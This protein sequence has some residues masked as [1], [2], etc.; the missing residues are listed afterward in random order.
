VETFR[1]RTVAVF[2]TIQNMPEIWDRLR[3]AMRRRA[4]PCI[5]AG[6]A[7]MEHLLQC[8][9]ALKTRKLCISGPMLM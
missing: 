5:Q 2:Q 4:E 7:H 3:V 1:N 6:D 8:N 9:V